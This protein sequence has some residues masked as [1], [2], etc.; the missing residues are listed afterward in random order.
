MRASFL[1]CTCA[2]ALGG[3]PRAAPPQA[4]ASTRTM[5]LTMGIFDQLKK[6]FD[7]EDYSKS[8]AKYEQTNARASHILVK[9]ESDAMEIKEQSAAG[10]LLFDEAA[11]KFSTCN[12]ARQGGK[13][14]KFVPG[15]MVKEFDDVVFG[16]KDT[17][18][19]FVPKHEINE[20]V[21][22]IQTQFGYHLIKIETRNMADFDFRAQEGKL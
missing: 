22:P 5:P 1:L 6:A 3:T 20:V 9:A 7:N 4:M 16:V 19:E 11:I 13:L 14:G 18:A 8:P 21:G 12:S 2:S 10:T 17:G 15:T